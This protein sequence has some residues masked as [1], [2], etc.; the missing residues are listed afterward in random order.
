VKFQSGGAINPLGGLT[1]GNFIS[2][3]GDINASG[4]GSNPSGLPQG[5][6]D[7]SGN[8]INGG[9]NFSGGGFFTG[10][11]LTTGDPSS[12]D[13]ASLSN[14]IF[15]GGWY[16]LSDKFS[17]T[18]GTSG[19]HVCP[20]PETMPPDTHNGSEM[21]DVHPPL[22]QV[23]VN[24]DPNNIGVDADTPPG[25]VA[26]L[27]DLITFTFQVTNTGNVDL[28]I[29]DLVDDNA[30]PGDTSD[31]FTPTEVL[32]ADGFNFGDVVDKGVFNPG[33]TWFFQAK[34]LATNPGLNTNTIKV[35]GSDSEGTMVMDDDPANYIINP[36]NI[37]KL[38]LVEPVNPGVGEDVVRR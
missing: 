33:E 28:T 37:E 38:V 17:L 22:P 12:G 21:P 11:W 24:F 20:N 5:P 30:T 10:Y 27:E 29:D 7:E 13:T 25:P 26:N 1:A 4:G 36:L 9:S 15:T 3:A 31:D 32:G 23:D 19:V 35:I 18:S 8:L 2:V 14:A 6:V 16:T 34:E